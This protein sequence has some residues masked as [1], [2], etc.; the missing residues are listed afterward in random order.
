MGKR[1]KQKGSAFEKEI[2]KK[3]SLWWTANERD[4]VFWRTAGSGARAN[5]RARMGQKTYGQHG[6]ICATNPI[7]DPL[8]DVLTLELKKGYND[9]TFQDL[10]DVPSDAVPKKWE[11]WL[12]QAYNSYLDSGSLGW[13]LIT[14]RDRKDALLTIPTELVELLRKEGAERIHKGIL[15]QM[16]VQPRFK[17]DYQ[18]KGKTLYELLIP[19]KLLSISIYPFSNFLNVVLPKHVISLQ[20]AS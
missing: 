17:S 6:D 9:A 10:L 18:K 7:G 5:V 8:I 11:E 1:S 13:C 12:V 14:K 2:C 20:E 16:N 15:A 3:L 19:D 4:D